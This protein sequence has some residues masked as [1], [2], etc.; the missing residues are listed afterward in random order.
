MAQ[1]LEYLLLLEDPD[2]I[3]SIHI[4]NHNYPELQFRGIQCLLVFTGTH[5]LNIHIHN[6]INLKY[7]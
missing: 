1:R 6:K 4:G 3:L 7:H 2:L 5:M